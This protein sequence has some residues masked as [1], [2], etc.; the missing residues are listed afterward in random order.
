MG[1]TVQYMIKLRSPFNKIPRT[2]NRDHGVRVITA[3]QITSR[4]AEEEA[5]RMGSGTTSGLFISEFFWTQLCL[6]CRV[7]K[8]LLPFAKGSFGRGCSSL[9]RVGVVRRT[10]GEAAQAVWAGGDRRAVTGV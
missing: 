9:V 7:H 5:K 6:F 2:T 3:L 10:W 4:K 1:A 8:P